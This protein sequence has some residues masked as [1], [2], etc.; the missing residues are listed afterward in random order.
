M[1]QIAQILAL[2]FKQVNTYIDVKIVLGILATLPPIYTHFG[3]YKWPHN[4]TLGIVTTAWYF[5]ISLLY[6]IYDK[7]QG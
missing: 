4:Y 1:H 7:Y 2:S 6:Y 3:P 5:M